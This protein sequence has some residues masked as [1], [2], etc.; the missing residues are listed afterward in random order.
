M[1]EKIRT[2]FAPSPT[3][4]LHMGNA[5]TALF[6]Y[7]FAK[8]HN[9][10][11]LLRIEDTDK[12]RS[13]KE[14]EKDIIENLRWLGIEWD[15]GIEKDDSSHGPYRQ[16]ERTDIY[17]GY[18]EKLFEEKK[19]YYC[20]CTSEELEAQKQEQSSRGETPRYS[21]RCK[22]LSAKEVQENIQ[23][24]KSSVIRF[25]SKHKTIS[26]KDLVRG[27]IEFKTELLGD[28]VI[29]KDMETPLYN[30]TA[31]IDDFEMH[32]TH[33]IRGEDHIPNTPK[34]I[35]I[36]EALRFDSVKYA[37]LPLLLGE[38]RTKLSKRHGESSVTKFREEGY[39]SEAVINFL[40]LLGW[41]PGGEKEVFSLS[42]L[43]KMF[44]LD[45]VQKGGAIFNIERLDWING[46]YIRKT[47]I[48]DITKLCIPFLV[49]AKLIKENNGN[50]ILNLFKRNKKSY[51]IIKT[52][53]TIEF[54]KLEK[55]I[56]LYHERLK[57]LSDIVELVDLF[58]VKELQY[59]KDL[60]YW[61]KSTDEKT[62]DA[63]EKAK[64]FLEN[65]DRKDWNREKLEKIILDKLK[66][67]NRG[68]ILWPL[69][70]AITGKKASASPF[71]VAELLGKE[72]TINRINYAEKLLS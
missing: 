45:K 47:P 54:A 57:K 19:A 6:N 49:E 68:V 22:N 38:D 28:F 25:I 13:K 71:E 17:K 32:I 60:L 18:I 63:L 11:F 23:N 3:G 35:L 37:H 21:G 51:A 1:A 10:S 2:R 29:A 14:W 58:F 64:G 48:K 59:S 55:I 30:F 27:K 52:G 20:F 61:K 31:V 9:G 34:Q 56:A 53:K 46:L 33:V 40:A 26:F 42:S 44:S 62:T 41:N 8:K 70:A 39:L 72:E 7:L 12:E 16:S 43:E 4:A 36:Q 66:D 24:K 65:I 15:E 67:E 5:R 69:R 50:N